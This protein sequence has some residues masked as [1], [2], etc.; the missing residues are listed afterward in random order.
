M[1]YS[2]D[3]SSIFKAELSRKVENPVG[4]LKWNFVDEVEGRD[5]YGGLSEGPTL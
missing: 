4:I 3:Q 2:S 5:K 1:F